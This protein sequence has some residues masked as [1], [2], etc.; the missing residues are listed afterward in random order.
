MNQT[1][2]NSF[3]PPVFTVGDD[4][5]KTIINLKPGDLAASAG[6]LQAENIRLTVDDNGHW[7]AIDKS[8]LSPVDAAG[9][10]NPPTA[11]IQIDHEMLTWY[12]HIKPSNIDIKQWEL[13][14]GVG[15]IHDEFIRRYSEFGKK[16]G[17]SCITRVQWAR[18]ADA[19]NLLLQY[20]KLISYIY[21][22]YWAVKH[23]KNFPFYYFN[24]AMTIDIS[25][26]QLESWIR[27]GNP[28]KVVK[29]AWGEKA[30]QR[31]H[32]PQR[33][34]FTPRRGG[35]GRHNPG[36]NN[37]QRGQQNRSRS[38][39]PARGGNNGKGKRGDSPARPFGQKG[40]NQDGKKVSFK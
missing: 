15:L 19:K 31:A 23:N 33:G 14:T 16:G 35:R 2:N 1:L 18:S 32:Q 8:T 3:T 39:S 26:I 40:R 7:K 17:A 25:Y 5:V 21:S 29:E 4:E 24:L 20:R 28:P 22:V 38:N 34:D 27:T 11:D 9:L 10:R 12:A 30:Q 37:R 36:R 6:L 13:Q